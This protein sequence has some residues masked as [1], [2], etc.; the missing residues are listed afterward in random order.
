MACQ[1]EDELA[2]GFCPVL[3]QHF[4][5]TNQAWFTFT[6]GAHVDS[7]DPYTLD[8]WYDFLELFVA[9]Q[10]PSVEASAVRAEAPLIYLFA[11]GISGV[12]LPPDPIQSL[13]T[14]A[15]ALA[16]FDA[17]PEVRVLFDN[18]AGPTPSGTVTAGDPYPA[19]EQSFSSLPIPGTVADYWYLGPSGTLTDAP[20]SASGVDSY[21]SNASAL[22]LTDYSP[23]TFTS[24]LWGNASVWKWNWKQ[25]PAGSA[26]SYVTAP[27]AADTTVIGGGAVDLWV[28]SSTPDVDFQATISEV[29]PDGNEVFVQDGWLRASERALATTSANMLA[30]PSTVLEPVPSFESADASPMPSGQFVEVDIPLYFE[31]HVYRAGSRIRVTIAAPNGTQPAWSFTQTQP[32][33]GTATESVA[34]SPSM[35]SSVILPVVPGVAVPTGLPPCGSLRNEP[36]RPYVPLVNN[37]S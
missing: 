1:W 3:V 30:Q 29:R 19:F 31:G 35:P 28:Q 33:S 36:C 21:T 7:L 23:L 27:L 4:T 24:G 18:G 22:P 17:L 13:G 34:F 32:S 16:A 26:V 12:K 11:F 9:H 15:S 10:A 8:R 2:G 14:Y 6:N 25:N 37:G 5:G 20:P